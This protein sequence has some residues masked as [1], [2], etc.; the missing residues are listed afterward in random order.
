MSGFAGEV[1][2]NKQAKRLLFFPSPNLRGIPM[3]LTYRA[4]NY[5]T[6]SPSL[7]GA[8]PVV[9]G[10][11]RSTATLIRLPVTLVHPKQAIGLQYRGAAYLKLH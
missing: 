6:I 5:E 3:K 10:Q 9:I 8:S 2:I 1:T 4:A 7:D 11:Y